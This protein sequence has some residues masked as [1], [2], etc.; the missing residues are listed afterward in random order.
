MKKH[1]VVMALAVLTAFTIGV[2]PGLARACINLSPCYEGQHT[3]S[4]TVE[5]GYP[6]YVLKSSMGTI[7]LIGADASKWVGQEVNARGELNKDTSNGVE[8]L[9]V[10][11]FDRP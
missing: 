11:R 4:G 2:A 5:R 7:R 8:I 10:D 9:T 1:I 3:I 6:G